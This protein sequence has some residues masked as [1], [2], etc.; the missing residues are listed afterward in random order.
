[1]IGIQ[2]GRYLGTRLGDPPSNDVEHFIRCPDCGGGSIVAIP[3]G[4]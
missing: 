1:M 4:C 2:R 3:V